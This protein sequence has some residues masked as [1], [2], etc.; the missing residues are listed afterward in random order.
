MKDFFSFLPNRG[1]RTFKRR[2]RSF[3]LQFNLD[4]GDASG[5][6]DVQGEQSANHRGRCI[7]LVVIP[8]SRI[9]SAQED[10]R[11]GQPDAECVPLILDDHFTK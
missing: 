4:A 11:F 3:P 8:A 2:S 6:H 1:P 9:G 10:D 5:F 7:F